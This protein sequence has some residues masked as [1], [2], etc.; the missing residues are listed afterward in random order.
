MSFKGIVLISQEAHFLVGILMTS[1]SGK[2]M[3]V[4]DPHVITF[5]GMTD[6]GDSFR[7]QKEQYYDSFKNINFLIKKT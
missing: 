5:L 1:Y 7:S 4:I 6:C 2:S 3:D